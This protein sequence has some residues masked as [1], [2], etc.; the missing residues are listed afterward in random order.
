MYMKHLTNEDV[1]MNSSD[2]ELQQNLI[3]NHWLL[4]SRKMCAAD[5]QKLPEYTGVL[6]PGEPKLEDP[7]KV[8]KA[9][10]A[11]CAKVAHS[12]FVGGVAAIQ[13]L[14][15]E[16]LRLLAHTPTWL[17]S[18]VLTNMYPCVA[19]KTSP[20]DTYV[21][22]LAKMLY[23]KAKSTEEAPAA[24]VQD[25]NKLTVSHTF[26]HEPFPPFH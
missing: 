25:E 3:V 13:P 5:F 18:A 20:V 26:S 17:L 22:Y 11:A 12:I 7:K 8:D 2:V 4:T 9:G 15:K 10:I 16:H 6:H 23:K 14:V 19:G 24:S 1:H 21:I